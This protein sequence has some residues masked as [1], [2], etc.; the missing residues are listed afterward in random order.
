MPA[1]KRKGHGLPGGFVSK[2][3][4]RFFYANKALRTKYAHKEAHKV[5]AR[6][7]KV[8]GYRSLPLRTGVRRRA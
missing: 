3:Q 7:G 1:R 6:R 2:K 5:I 4:W 8:T